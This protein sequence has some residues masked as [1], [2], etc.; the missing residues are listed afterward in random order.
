MRWERAMT[1]SAAPKAVPTDAYSAF[2]DSSG[3]Y[4]PVMILKKALLDMRGV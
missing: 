1:M 2:C 4:E 3:P